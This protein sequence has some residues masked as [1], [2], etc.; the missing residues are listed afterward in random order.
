MT[1][2]KMETEI[3]LEKKLNM[4]NDLNKYSAKDT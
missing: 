3:F 4:G 2:N 1:A